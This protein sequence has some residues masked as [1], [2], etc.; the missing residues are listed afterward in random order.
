LIKHGKEFSY[1]FTEI[2]TF[3]YYC[4]VHP[5]MTGIV[6]VDANTVPEF[7][8]VYLVFVIGMIVTLLYRNR[9]RIILGKQNLL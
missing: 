6:I 7:P 1:T 9:F 4:Q 5:A 8:V 3:N 2:G